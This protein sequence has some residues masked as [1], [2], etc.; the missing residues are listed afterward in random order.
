MAFDNTL[1]AFIH[2]DVYAKGME[3]YFK[4][5]GRGS[6][7]T[8]KFILALLNNDG[9]TI[10]ISGVEFKEHAAD[11]NPQSCCLQISDWDLTEG[12]KFSNKE[13]ILPSID[14]KYTRSLVSNED[15]QNAS[16]FAVIDVSSYTVD[17]DDYQR[18]NIEEGVIA[19][20]P[21]IAASSIVN[22]ASAEGTANIGEYPVVMFGSLSNTPS[23]DSATNFYFSGA[24]I[25]FTEAA[26]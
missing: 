20:P 23:I 16:Y 26:N 12:A 24:T 1:S 17:D 6:G 25:Q 9:N 14:F 10:A 21:E 2:N 19:Y 11:T 7:N 13:L 15:P 18:T 3:Y 22:V 5:N 4:Q 8:S